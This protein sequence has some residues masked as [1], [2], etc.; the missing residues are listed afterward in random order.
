MFGWDG[1]RFDNAT[2]GAGGYDFWGKKIDGDDPKKKDALEARAWAHMRDSVWKQLGPNFVIGDN[3]DRQFRDRSP[4][5]WDESCRKGQ[6]L[7]EEV[8][9][10][11]YSA[12]SPTNR[13]HDYMVF[14]HNSGEAVRALGGHHLTIGFD[15]QYPV[16]HMYLS[17]FTYAGRTHAYANL[18]ADTLP[19]GNHAAFATRYSAL[20]W[21][22]D[23]VK[24]LP[25]PEKKIAVQSAQ[26]IWWQEYATVRTTPEGKRQYILHLINPPVQERV[27]SDVTNKVPAPQKNFTVTLKLDGGEKIT[28]ATLLSPDP[29]IRQV[30]LPVTAQAGQ[31]SV[32]VP[33]L[34]F[35][36]MLVFD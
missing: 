28:R 4:A 35:W 12:D 7:M 9:R 15:V 33:D 24:A 2:Y 5:A 22:I 21:D 20:L 19:F 32:T 23:R 17:I 34:Y 3:C 18:H 30:T 10:S 8:P 36:D 29:V 11:S 27:H 16:D 25:E 6:L 1:I 26:P 14:Y 13:W 31:V